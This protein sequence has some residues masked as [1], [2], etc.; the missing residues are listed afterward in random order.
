MFLPRYEPFR[1]ANAMKRSENTVVFVHGI[2]SD[3][4]TFHDMAKGFEADDR[5]DGWD[6]KWFEYDFHRSIENNGRDLAD[7]L[8]QHFRADDRVVLV[9]HSMGGLVGR[10]AILGGQVP[11]VRKLFLLG[12]PNFGAVRQG[13]LGIIALWT[14][15]ETRRL[16]AVY[17]RQTGVL[18]LTNV[19]GVFEKYMARHEG[20]EKHAESVQYITIPGLFF[21]ENRP[22]LEQDDGGNKSLT[23]LNVGIEFASYA[24]LLRIGIE[25]PHDGI[26]EDESNCL[27]PPN[28]KVE[29]YYS[30]KLGQI[31]N[32]ATTGEATYA[33]L[34]PPECRGLTHVQIH[35]DPRVIRLV[36][37][38][39]FH[40]LLKD[41]HLR[42]R[43]SGEL[44]RFLRKVV[45]GLEG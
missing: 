38:L 37:D 21:H 20:C 12:T 39:T 18:D 34:A 29:A 44:S 26:V 19:N 17:H 25:K 27:I 13:R 31:Q 15:R 1:I 6:L 3:H 32:P 30:E 9:G 33:H 11:C 36:Q 45:P 16:W 7:Y 8:H 43:E 2:Y 40:D 5:F 14:L 10:M 24:A 41:W 28:G 22:L 35:K 23:I 4:N 42:A